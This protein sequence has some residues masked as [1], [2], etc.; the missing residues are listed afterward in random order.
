[1]A[2]LAIKAQRNDLDAWAEFQQL[3]LEEKLRQRGMDQNMIG[4]MSDLMIQMHLQ[5]QSFNFDEWKTKYLA[6]HE[7][8]LTQMGID[9]NEAGFFDYFAATANA[10]GE[11]IPG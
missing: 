8:E 3:S 5:Q 1:M 9:A 4:I 6:E 10:I 2:D 11:A 7:K